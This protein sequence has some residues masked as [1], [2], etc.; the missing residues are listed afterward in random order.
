M[1]PFPIHMPHTYVNIAEYEF[2]GGCEK[3]VECDEGYV[4]GKI[5]NACMSCSFKE[6]TKQA[7]EEQSYG[8]SFKEDNEEMGTGWCKVC[9]EDEFFAFKKGTD[10]NRKGWGLYSSK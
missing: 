5:G 1:L 3:G 4:C 9:S 7:K 8:F 6:C 10:I 2:I